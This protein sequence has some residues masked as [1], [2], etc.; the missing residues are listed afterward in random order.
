MEQITNT[1]ETL[2]GQMQEKYDALD[3]EQVA[4]KKELI[5]KLKQINSPKELTEEQIT[6]L[7][8][9]INSINNKA[10]DFNEKLAAVSKKTEL[11]SN[12]N[13]AKAI[14]EKLFTYNKSNPAKDLAE[15]IK[16]NENYLN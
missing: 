12:L 14:Q 6:S 3:Y 7:T 2:K 11:I 15:T 1:L 4:K 16:W 8:T 10:T 5:E 9:Q 13:N